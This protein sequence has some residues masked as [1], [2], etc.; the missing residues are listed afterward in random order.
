MR[1][2]TNRYRVTLSFISLV[3]A[4]FSLVEL[5]LMVRILLDFLRASSDALFVQ[6]VNR[7]TDPLLWPFLGTFPPYELSSGFVVQFHEIL[8]LIVY[9]FVGYLLVQGITILGSHRPL[10]VKDRPKGF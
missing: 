9:A 8:A 4:T 2:G 6:W 5:M 1:I 7:I 3:R 10:F